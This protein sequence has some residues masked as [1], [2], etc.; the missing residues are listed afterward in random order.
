MYYGITKKDL[1]K[2]LVGILTLDGAVCDE[3]P[4]CEPV[5]QVCLI[6]MGNGHYGFTFDIDENVIPFKSE[7]YIDSDVNDDYIVVEN[8]S[9]PVYMDM[10]NR[11]ANEIYNYIHPLYLKD[12]EKMEMKNDYAFNPDDYSL[13]VCENNAIKN[14]IVLEKKDEMKYILVNWD[15]D[16]EYLDRVVK[17]FLD[18]KLYY[19][20][21]FGDEFENDDF[22]NHYNT[23]ERLA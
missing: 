19:N 22:R 20:D 1:V 3:T 9:N 8:E 18:N 13:Y 7:C 16:D 11:M 12:K 15:V 21:I 2:Q 14:I 10:V 23:F 5:Y 17:C 6:D 4:F